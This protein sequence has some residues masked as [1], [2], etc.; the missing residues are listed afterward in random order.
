[1]QAAG[2]GLGSEGRLGDPCSHGQLAL[3]FSNT[4]PPQAH[5]PP[6]NARHP[7]SH[8]TLSVPLRLTWVPAALLQCA[9]MGWLVLPIN[10]SMPDNLWVAQRTL[11][12]LPP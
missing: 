11:R 8:A 9:S 12:G 3:S 4:A 6:A 7:A 1:V 5:P 2:A 10:A